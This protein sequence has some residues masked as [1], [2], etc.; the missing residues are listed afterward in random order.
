MRR[1]RTFPPQWN[2]SLSILLGLRLENVFSD[3]RRESLS[4]HEASGIGCNDKACYVAERDCDSVQMSCSVL[5]QDW[6]HPGKVNSG[7]QGHIAFDLIK[8]NGA[9]S[10]QDV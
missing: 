6:I 3:G 10:N 2:T 8:K 9:P 5:Q 7:S 4:V 1:I